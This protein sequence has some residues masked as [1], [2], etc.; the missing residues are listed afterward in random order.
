MTRFLLVMSFAVFAVTPAFGQSAAE[1]Q[2]AADIRMLEQRIERIET[3]LSELTQGVGKQLSEQENATRK[4]SA[5]LTV[6][7]NEAQEAVRVLREQ[8]AET[9]QRL[10]AMLERSTAPDG[11]TELFDNARADYMAGNYPLA[12]QGFTEFLKAAPQHGNAASAKYY[13]GEAYR[14]ERKLTEALASY[15]RLIGEHPKSEQIPNA[16]VRRAEVLNELGRV[17]E[18]RA[19]YETVVKESPN[20]DAATFA[21]QRLAAL[22]R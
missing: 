22:G 11:A 15:D 9:N 21:K 19:E 20:T 6:R 3:A 8:L 1:R 13:M 17:K 2:L 10:T 12:V 14:L 16:R 5:D 18:A 4:L 7:L